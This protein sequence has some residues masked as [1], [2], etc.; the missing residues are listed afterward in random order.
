MPTALTGA[1]YSINNV[2]GWAVLGTYAL[3]K[4]VTLDAFQ[5]LNSKNKTTGADGNERTRVQINYAF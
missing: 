4:N 5:T 3:A 1:N 2:K